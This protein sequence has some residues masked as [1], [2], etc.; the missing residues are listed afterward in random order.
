MGGI[1]A[2]VVLLGILFFCIKMM[3]DM[4]S[5]LKFN[6]RQFKKS[7]AMEEQMEKQNAD[8][9]LY[10]YAKGNKIPSWAYERAVKEIKTYCGRTKHITFSSYMDANKLEVVPLTETYK[11]EPGISAQELKLACGVRIREFDM[12]AYVRTGKLLPKDQEVMDSLVKMWF[13]AEPNCTD[14]KSA[15]IHV[16][17]LFRSIFPEEYQSAKPKIVVNERGTS[18]SRYSVVE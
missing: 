12:E 1:I 6:F 18:G 10:R 4:I 17:I 3:K 2:I 5:V 8:A 9:I 14:M 13:F 11:M 16:Q 15:E 7:Q